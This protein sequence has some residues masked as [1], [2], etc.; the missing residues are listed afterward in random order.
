MATIYQLKRRVLIKKKNHKTSPALK[1][2][3]QAKATVMRIRVVTPRKPNS[4]RRQVVKSL[5]FD[6]TRVTAYIPGIGHNLR[7]HSNIL[8]RGGGARDL[9]GV[10]YTCCRG[11]YDFMGSLNKRRRR[12]VYGAKWPDNVF[13]K[14]R[15]IYRQ[16][17]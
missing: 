14:R 3:P 16:M 4:A 8:V 13:K 1:G 15:R 5:L 10:R 9:P 12:S 17:K 7:R 2:N 6:D 11:V